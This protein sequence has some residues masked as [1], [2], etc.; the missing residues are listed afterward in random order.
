[1][2]TSV[3]AVVGYYNQVLIFMS[4]SAAD[5]KMHFPYCLLHLKFLKWLTRVEDTV[6]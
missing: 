1:M 6:E 3:E 4:S 5:L 2:A